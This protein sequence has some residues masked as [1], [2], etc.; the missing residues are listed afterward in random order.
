LFDLKTRSIPRN[1]V[2]NDILDWE[3]PRLWVAQIPN[4]VRAY[5]KSGKFTDIEVLDMRSSISAWETEKQAELKRFARLLRRIV[6]AARSRVDGKLEI[7]HEN[8]DV[9]ELRE[10]TPNMPPAFSPDTME[11]WKRWLGTAVEPST[12]GESEAESSQAQTEGSLDGEG[13]VRDDIDDWCDGSEEE[14]DYT[15]CDNECGYCGHC[16]Y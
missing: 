4:F 6:D 11:R 8:G 5:H 16:K 15:A 10:Q 12:S 3:L 9:L 14:G 7:V 13:D 2:Q 1:P